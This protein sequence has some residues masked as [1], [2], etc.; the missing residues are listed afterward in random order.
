VPA[1]AVV[2]REDIAAYFKER[3]WW[4]PTTMGGHPLAMAAM[5]ATI[6]EMLENNLVERAAETGRYLEE[7]LRRL[8]DRHPCVAS[9]A[10]DGL[11]W[12]LELARPDGR[13]YVDEDR[14]HM[15][16]GDIS[17]WPTQ[18]VTQAC[19]ESDV[20]ITGFVPNTLRLGPPLTVTREECDHALTALEK[21]LNRL[22][23]TP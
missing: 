23:E 19:L 14:D 18:I 15:G 9:V 10:G 7:R 12:V 5:V 21:A 17:G 16:A 13:Q 1:A 4:L 8:G 3:R 11:F 2:V 22:A 6:E 20:F